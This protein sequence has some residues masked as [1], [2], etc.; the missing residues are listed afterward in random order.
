MLVPVI[1]LAVAL[2]VVGACLGKPGGWL[3]LGLAVISLLMLA[4]GWPHR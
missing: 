2:I 4:A 1:L 3:V